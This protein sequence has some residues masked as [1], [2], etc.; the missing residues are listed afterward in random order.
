MKAPAACPTLA[1][2]TETMPCRPESARKAR[3]LIARALSAWDLDGLTDS[4]KLV[5][6]ELVGNA[7]RH[8]R[9]HSIRVTISR[10]D[11][12]CVR[13]AVIDKSAKKAV[14]RVAPAGGEG[15]RGL[16]V[17]ARLSEDTGTDP[18]SWGKRVWAQ[19]RLPNSNVPS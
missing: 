17:V 19:L 9:C 16:A 11:T 8:T 5:V 3:V 2:Y 18:F 15:G 10:L 7:A 6:S 14:P 1:A 4:A 12:D 13:I